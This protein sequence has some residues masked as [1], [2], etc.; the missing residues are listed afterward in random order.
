MGEH[1]VSGDSERYY[2][3]DGAGRVV[4]TAYTSEEAQ[5]IAD[6]LDADE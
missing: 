5:A 4:A 3:T 6:Q 1:T 2:V